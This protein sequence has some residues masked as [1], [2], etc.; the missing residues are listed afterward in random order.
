[1]A[2]YLGNTRVDK[3]PK[4][5]DIKK[6]G[7]G[8][9]FLTNDGTY[10]RIINDESAESENTVYSAKQT[11]KRLT[12]VQNTL[13]AGQDSQVNM[14]QKTTIGATANMPIYYTTDDTNAI[15]KIIVQCYKFV[16]GDK[17]VVQV[18]KEFN[19]GDES[20]FYHTD[21]V[22]FN[23]VARIKDSYILENTLNEDGLYESEIINKEEFLL[24]NGISIA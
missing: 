16:P 13:V 11:E 22:E 9:Q 7:D 21:N 10:K 20:N 4:P 17:G 2:I 12:E 24:L 8:T 18:L 19:N 1:M 3:I 5:I 15:D 23:G 14:W 6:D